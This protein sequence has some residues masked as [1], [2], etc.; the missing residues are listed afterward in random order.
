MTDGFNRTDLNRYLDNADLG[1]WRGVTGRDPASELP[2]LDLFGLV[3]LGTWED[4][5]TVI[6]EHGQTALAELDR[7]A[8][9]T[10]RQREAA[11]AV[12]AGLNELKQANPDWTLDNPALFS[13]AKQTWWDSISRGADAAA[14]EW[15]G[16]LGTFRLVS[17]ADLH[18]SLRYRQLPDAAKPMLVNR[19]RDRG[20]TV[21]TALPDPLFTEVAA[22]FPKGIAQAIYPE[23]FEAGSPSFS[24]THRA[25]LADL[26]AAADYYTRNPAQYAKERSVTAK[27]LSAAESDSQVSDFFSAYYLQAF[28]AE[29]Q[30]GATF[31]Q[32]AAALTQMGIAE[33]DVRQLVASHGGST[34]APAPAPAP[35]PEPVAKPQ[36]KPEKPEKPAPKPAPEP[37]QEEPSKRGCIGSVVAILLILGAVLGFYAY[38]DYQEQEAEKQRVSESLESRKRASESEA[39]SASS[40]SASMASR[41]ASQ[42]SERR[43]EA[44]E[45][46]ARRASTRARE[47]VTVEKTVEPAPA[48]APAPQQQPQYQQPQLEEAWYDNA[49]ACENGRIDYYRQ[50]GL[51]PGYCGPS[52]G[53]YSF[54]Y[55]VF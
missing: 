4:D 14:D 8:T 45:E 19:L 37:A 13:L 42:E 16:R 44:E 46:A 24:L 10:G 2:A 41:S 23:Q 3:Q 51:Q 31:D 39:S 48:P 50:T 47:T 52:Y 53:G 55:Q 1:A 36:P 26:K 33:D 9:G 40:R 7:L 29:R 43:R 17:E 18:D 5:P 34:G 11:S 15:V 22:T 28:R 25:T 6:R 54:L 27:L 12:V 38:T 49:Q 20:I 32:G 30:R 21:T 35:A